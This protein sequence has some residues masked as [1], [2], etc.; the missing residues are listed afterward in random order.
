MVTEVKQHHIAIAGK[1]TR[2]GAGNVGGRRPKAIELKARDFILKVIGGDDG[3]KK[4]IAKIFQQATRGSFK[5]QELLLNYILGKPVDR[6]KIESNYGAEAVQAP[7]IK[8]IADNLRLQKLEKDLKGAPPEPITQERI[9]EMERLLNQEM[10]KP[11][12]NEPTPEVALD[13]GMPAEEKVKR[14]K[15]A[16]KVKKT[17]KKK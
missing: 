17:K 7:I 11:T 8:I 1:A 16:S 9:D 2:F 4:L 12:N 10:N 15:A 3:V 14:L 13:N 6:V 5:H